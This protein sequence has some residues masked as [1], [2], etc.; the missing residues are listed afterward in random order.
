MTPRIANIRNTI[1]M[2]TP[3]LAIDGIDAIRASIRVFIEELWDK[4]RSGLRIRRSLR[5]LRK[6]MSTPVMLNENKI[7]IEY[8]LR[9]V[10]ESSSNDETVHA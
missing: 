5:T 3:T 8:Y 2:T 4:K 7:N 10:N 1:T 9:C 6:A